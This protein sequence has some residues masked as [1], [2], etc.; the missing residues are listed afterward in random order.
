LRKK[1]A[2]KEKK[3]KETF[4]ITSKLIQKLVPLIKPLWINSSCSRAFVSG[5]GVRMMEL[6]VDINFT[7]LYKVNETFFRGI[8]DGT[9]VANVFTNY[10]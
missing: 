5:I 7:S 8:V 9:L 2:Y 10:L 1:I 6:E 4:K 3:V